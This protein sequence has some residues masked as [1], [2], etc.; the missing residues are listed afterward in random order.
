MISRHFLG[1]KNKEEKEIKEGSLLMGNDKG[2]YLWLNKNP[3]SRYEGWFC[4]ID[5]ELFRVIESIK[6]NDTEEP[7]EIENRFTYFKRKRGDIEELF[8][9]S[10][11][12]HVLI[13]EL[14]MEKHI[15]IFFDMRRSYDL[16]DSEDYKFSREEEIFVVEFSN[17]LYLAINCIEGENLKETVTRDYL[18]DKERNSPPFAKQIQK[19]LSLYGKRFVFAIEKSKEEAV[20]EARRIFLR[21]VPKK[22]DRIDIYC[23]KNSLMNLLVKDNPGLCAGL[24]WFFQFWPRD[25]AISLK[26]LFWIDPKSAREIYFRLLDNATKKGPTG[27]VNADAVGWIFKRTE[28]ILPFTSL[29]EK[30]KIKRRIKKYIEESLWSFTENNLAINKPKETWMDS[31]DRDGARIEIQAMRLNMYKLAG[32]LANRKSEKSLYKDMEKTMREKVRNIFFDGDNLYDGYCVRKKTIDKTIRPNIFITAYIYPDLLSKEEW[33]KCFDNALELL[34]LPW[35]G[36]SS[37]QKNDSDFHEDHTGE[38]SDS[39]HQ[40]DSWFYINNLTALVLYR[41]DKKKY[42]Y[43]IKKIIKASKEELMWKGALG[44]H[45]ELSSAK[46]LRS[47][48]CPNQAWSSAMYLEMIKE[49]ELNS[50]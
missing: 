17:G 2:D 32:L 13:Y 38:I 28:D 49:I 14:S 30:E 3:K 27:V 43:Y 42:D 35:G 20:R 46:E 11:S 37:L 15:D 45:S 12:S 36:V 31:L 22:E 48:G 4:R 5:N 40:G 34:W 29:M 16:K 7:S 21:D 18:Y 10:K 6:P 24:P 47:E 8:Y 23:A 39:Y 19:G 1:E 26:A 41:F 50:F 33:I 44:C 9:F 25:E